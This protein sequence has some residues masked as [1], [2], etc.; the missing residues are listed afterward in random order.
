MLQRVLMIGALIAGT[1]LG[2]LWPTR[3]SATQAIPSEIALEKSADGQFYADAQVN[4]H[5]THFLVDT[6]A[7]EIAITEDDAK[8]AGIKIDP[9]NYE[10]VGEGA[11]GVV[12]GQHVEIQSIE[13]GGVREQNVDVVV[14]PGAEVS[15]LGQPF[16]DRMDEIVIHKNEMRLR[17]GSG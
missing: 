15:L 4:G 10:L 5:P 17:Y 11:S 12:R 8:R 3:P 16:L 14:V 1:A 9:A 13:L 6:G 2:F 7:S